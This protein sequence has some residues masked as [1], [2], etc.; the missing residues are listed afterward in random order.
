[1]GEARIALVHGGSCSCPCRSHA[2]GSV[3][4]WPSVVSA[5]RTILLGASSRVRG[6]AVECGEC[7]SRTR[8]PGR[9]AGP[10]RRRCRSSR[11]GSAGGV[12]R[13]CGVCAMP[14]VPLRCRVGRWA[15]PGGELMGLTNI[16]YSSCSPPRVGLLPPRPPP[17]NQKHR[18]RARGEDQNVPAR[19]LGWQG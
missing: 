10:P 16:Y 6:S 4:R 13:V 14:R 5:L 7:G 1:M 8:P 9:A 15:V 19:W 18:E 17:G 2:A 11:C 3:G 12:P